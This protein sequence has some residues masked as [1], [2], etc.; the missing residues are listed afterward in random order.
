MQIKRLSIDQVR[1]LHRLEIGAGQDWVSIGVDYMIGVNI[2]LGPFWPLRST[3]DWQRSQIVLFKDL[4]YLIWHKSWERLEDSAFK[5]PGEA[6]YISE[7]AAVHQVDAEVHAMDYDF[8]PAKANAPVS[9]GM[10]K[11]MMSE[12]VASHGLER[13]DSLAAN[14]Y[15]DE[16]A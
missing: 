14:A 3:S 6:G 12:K 11:L 4:I 10:S 1:E 9:E 15:V 5:E 7:I 2:R 8:P 16:D 13:K